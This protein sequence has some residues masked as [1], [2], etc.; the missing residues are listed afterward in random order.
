MFRGLAFGPG[1][2]IKGRKMNQAE[3]RLPG[4]EVREAELVLLATPSEQAHFERIAKLSFPWPSSG[5]VWLEPAS[6]PM[7]PRPAW[8]V[9]GSQRPAGLAHLLRRKSLAYGAASP[10]A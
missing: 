6:V 2:K 8:P 9:P 10:P 7:G 1:T 3:Y 4:N 5:A